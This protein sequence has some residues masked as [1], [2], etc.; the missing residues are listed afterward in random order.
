[1]LKAALGLMALTL[2]LIGAAL[3]LPNPEPSLDQRVQTLVQQLYLEC[4]R[5]SGTGNLHGL[6]GC[7]AVI[8]QRRYRRPDQVLLCCS[9][10][11]DHRS[12]QAA[13]SCNL[14]Q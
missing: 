6:F 8:G 14:G 1:M 7:N 4:T 11:A 5:M 3:V 10:R 2:G 12:K 9:E 13:C